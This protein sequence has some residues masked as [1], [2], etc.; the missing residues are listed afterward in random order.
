M[1]RE[2]DIASG[3]ANRAKFLEKQ[4]YSK[5]YTID[6]IIKLLKTNLEMLISLNDYAK[7]IVKD[8][9]FKIKLEDYNKELFKKNF[10]SLNSTDTKG[11]ACQYVWIS[12]T[13]DGQPY[14]VG[15]TSFKSDFSQGI[16]DI[17]KPISLF[18]KKWA[19]I[20]VNVI[21][22]YSSDCKEN[23]QEEYYFINE[24]YEYEKI[25]VVEI[26]NKIN[27]NLSS[28]ITEAIIIPLDISLISYEESKQITNEI[29]TIVGEYLKM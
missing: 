13:S 4:T 15:R 10:K 8:N 2:K 11:S 21:Y 26:I 18:E 5:Y 1:R 20:L 6:E 27:K 28:F 24:K 12:F 16:G 17:E 19:E 7:Y 9:I 29:E 25:S 3:I 14:V 22:E 23:K